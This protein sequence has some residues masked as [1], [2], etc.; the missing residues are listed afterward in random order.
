MTEHIECIGHN[1]SERD[2]YIEKAVSYPKGEN[3]DC[4]DSKEY[5]ER[6]QGEGSG[7]NGKREKAIQERNH[8]IQENMVDTKTW[9][10]FQ[11]NNHQR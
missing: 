7:R 9:K 10:N 11:R 5:G 2:Q 1:A 3:H 8:P 4:P 6:D